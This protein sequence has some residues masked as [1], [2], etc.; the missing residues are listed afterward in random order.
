MNHYAE[1]CLCVCIFEKNQCK[2]HVM[3]LFDCLERS[4]SALEIRKGTCSRLHCCSDGCCCS[5][6]LEHSVAGDGEKNCCCSDGSSWCSSSFRSGAGSLAGASALAWTGQRIWG[7]AVKVLSRAWHIPGVAWWLFLLICLSLP[8]AT[9]TT[10]PHRLWLRL[11]LEEEPESY[12]F[13]KS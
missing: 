8:F 9:S 6:L 10:H 3:L 7:R 11:R 1:G 5:E 12:S 4:E 2:L 13:Y